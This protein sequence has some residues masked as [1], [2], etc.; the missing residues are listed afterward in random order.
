M[1]EVMRAGEGGGFR[2]FLGSES[3]DGRMGI[4]PPLSCC[5]VALRESAPRCDPLVVRVQHFA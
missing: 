2:E 3:G 4:S 1:D 5:H